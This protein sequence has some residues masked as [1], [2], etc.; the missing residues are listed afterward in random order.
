MKKRIFFNKGF[1]GNKNEKKVFQTL[2]TT[3]MM[4][5][6]MQSVV[7]AKELKRKTI[8]EVYKYYNNA[9]NIENGLEYSVIARF[10][11]STNY[12]SINVVES[13]EW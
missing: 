13:G 5:D 6:I 8:N 4:D 12:L 1:R 11:K 9:L 7:N 10:K 2:I 3:I